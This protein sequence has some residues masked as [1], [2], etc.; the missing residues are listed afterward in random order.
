MNLFK[1]RIHAGQVLAEFLQ[2]AHDEKDTL[3]LALPRGGVPVAYELAKAFDLPLDVWLVR[4]LG[5]PYQPEVAMGA[6]SLG[7]V[8]VL[9]QDLLN[10]VPVS[11]SEIKAVIEQETIELERRNKRYR[12][13]KPLPNLAG[14]E[15]ILVDDGA[16][17]GATLKAAINSLRKFRPKKITVALPLAS[18]E[19]CQEIEPLVDQLVVVYVP[20]HFTSVGSY[21]EDFRQLDDHDVNHILQL[22]REVIFE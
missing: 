1:D 19:A 16:A 4:K 21:Y 9:N 11:E 7:D 18:A 8:K 5:L 6:I 3:I 15:I 20:D 12:D 10:H 13:R 14:R 2:D 22:A 17:T